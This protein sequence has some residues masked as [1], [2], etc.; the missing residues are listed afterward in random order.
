MRY[1]IFQKVVKWCIIRKANLSIFY[2]VS[3]GL[4]Y[5]CVCFMSYFFLK[6]K[7]TTIQFI[8]MGLILAGII[9]M[10]MSR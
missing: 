5:T 8:G 3:A 6:E 1:F 4:V 7:I 2:S 9:T 10:N